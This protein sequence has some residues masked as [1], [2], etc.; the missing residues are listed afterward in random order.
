MCT[1]D[2]VENTLGEVLETKGQGR[3]LYDFILTDHVRG[4]SVVIR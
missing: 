3:D 4:D 2:Q 1:V